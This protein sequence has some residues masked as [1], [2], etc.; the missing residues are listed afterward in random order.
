MQCHAMF[1][2]RALTVASR[3][4]KSRCLS[5]RGAYLGL[6]VHF[7]AGSSL[8]ASVRRA[9]HPHSKKVLPERHTESGSPKSDLS[10]HPSHE[11]TTFPEDPSMRP[12]LSVGGGQARTSRLSVQRE[13][14]STSMPSCFNRGGLKVRSRFI[15]VLN[16]RAGG[17]PGCWRGGS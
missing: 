13:P 8:S 12:P 1:P 9:P 6:L 16:I 15:H 3:A 14:A 11:S 17:G 7:A 4:G 5:R 10:P 2:R